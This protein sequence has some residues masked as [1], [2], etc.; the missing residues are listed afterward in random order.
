VD[1]WLTTE[2]LPLVE[3]RVTVARDGTIHLAYRHTNLEEFKHLKFRLEGVLNHIGMRAHRL[4][5]RNFLPGA[6]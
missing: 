5:E 3:N 2:D 4:L 6:G 1:F